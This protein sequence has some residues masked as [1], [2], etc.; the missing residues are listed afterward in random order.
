VL[1]R[2]G[3][4]TRAHSRN[5]AACK[6]AS[7]THQ[8]WPESR[9][10]SR[11]DSRREFIPLRDL[12]E[13][14]L[15]AYD[16]VAQRAYEKFIERGNLTGDKVSDWLSAERELLPKLPAD[17][18]D[19]EKF[20]YALVSVPGPN[21]RRI[22]VG[23]ESQ[24]LVVLAHSQK[25]EG[26]EAVRDVSPIACVM[27]LPAEVDPATSTVIRCDKLIGIRMPKIATHGLRELAGARN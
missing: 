25:D 7:T 12:S 16:F 11:P 10:E 15:D 5:S 3:G 22:S 18:Q 9:Q 1:K 4:T 8:P 26:T 27:E 6:P 13:C 19:S 17:V 14:L 2:S 20:V 23:I 21:S 24:W